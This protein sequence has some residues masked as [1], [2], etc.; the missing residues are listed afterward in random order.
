VTRPEELLEAALSAEPYSPDSTLLAG[1]AVTIITGSELVIVGGSAVNC[2]VETYLP[3][4]LDLVGPVGTE[5][6]ARLEAYG[7]ERRGRHYVLERLQGRIEVEFP[8]SQL[9]GIEDPQ[10][11]EVAEGVFA[12]LISLNDLMMDRLRQATDGTDVTFDE[13]VRLAVGAYPSID[14]DSIHRR[15]SVEGKELAQLPSAL[16]RVQSRAKRLLRASKQGEAR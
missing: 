2:Y 12:A 14:W 1:A 4:D 10:R 6:I 9:V 8:A 3:T 16:K 11:V 5:E 13:A 15:V 7:F